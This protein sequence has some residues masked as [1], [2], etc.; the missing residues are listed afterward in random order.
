[1][2]LRCVPPLVRSILLA[3]V[4]T[5]CRGSEEPPPSFPILV[6]VT[7]AE[8]GPVVGASVSLDGKRIG[9]SQG[10]GTMALSLPGHEGDVRDLAVACPEGFEAPLKPLRVTLRRFSGAA[11]VPELEA[12]CRPLQH[13]IVVAVRAVGGAGL[14][15]LLRGK[16]IARTDESGVAHARFS[17]RPGEQLLLELDTRSDASLRPESPQ[18]LFVVGER[19]DVYLFD[20]PLHRVVARSRRARSS[21]PGPR[22]IE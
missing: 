5:A 4:A 7:S 6:R 16:E 2:V 15:V 22:R 17:L 21:P 19:D 20:A 12:T 10:D 1:M 13:T 3:L 8:E 9:T 18:K 14:P 11:S